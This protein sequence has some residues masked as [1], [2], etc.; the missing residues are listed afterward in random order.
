MQAIR[1]LSL[2]GSGRAILVIGM[3][4][5]VIYLVAT[6]LGI[7][8]APLDTTPMEAVMI[9]TPPQNE[10]L[11]QP[12][13]KPELIEPTLEIPQPDVIPIPEV[14]VPIDVPTSS[15]VTAATEAVEAT[16]LTVS[17]RVAPQYPPQ[18][19]RLGEEGVV[20]FRVLVD[21]NGRP[22][23]VN[24]MK[25]SGYSRLDDSAKRA[26]GK[27]TFV[28]P[29]RDGQPVRSWSRVQVRFRLDA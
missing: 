4:V 7:I 17:N 8:K 14:E 25:S 2:G 15:A 27:W 13:I 10:P 3:H 6:S 22:M 28:P 5:L 11:E 24:V 29:T 16:Q 9:E 19:R 23:Q 26:I 20:I 1:N 18:S 12:V 21:E